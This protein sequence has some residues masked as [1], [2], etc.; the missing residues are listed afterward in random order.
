MRYAC[1]EVDVKQFNANTNTLLGRHLLPI[2]LIALLFRKKT[3]QF[4]GEMGCRQILELG[5]SSFFTNW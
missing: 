2:L 4:F 3:R 5:I 1:V